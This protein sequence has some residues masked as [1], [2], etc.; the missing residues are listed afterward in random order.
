MPSPGTMMNSK[1]VPHCCQDSFKGSKSRML[2]CLNCALQTAPPAKDKL[3][4]CG[5]HE[6]S[7]FC[8]K[9][10]HGRSTCCGMYILIYFAETQ[11]N[12]RLV[13][14]STCVYIL[15]VLLVNGLLH[16][17]QRN[18][19]TCNPSI[20]SWWNM[21]HFSWGIFVWHLGRPKLYQVTTT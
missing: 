3:G 21:R 4:N 9:H 16:I 11:A 19:N 6:R 8:P 17:P 15:S 20:F 12:E 18:G 10:R 7:L 2:P 14:L 5:G 13:T 1:H